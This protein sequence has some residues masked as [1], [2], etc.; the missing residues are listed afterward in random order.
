MLYVQ[1]VR[2]F[3]CTLWFCLQVFG[4]EKA[5]VENV[6]EDLSKFVAALP[7]P[8]P[9]PAVAH[10]HTDTLDSSASFGMED[11]DE[12]TDDITVKQVCEVSVK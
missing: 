7:K 6:V 2:P 5:A 9:R 10:I 8:S 1:L 3:A 12:R 4:R 11:D